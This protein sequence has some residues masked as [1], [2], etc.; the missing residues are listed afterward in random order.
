[1]LMQVMGRH[2]QGASFVHPK[3]P[4]R[5]AL[6]AAAARRAVRITALGDEYTPVGHVVDERAIANAV[7]GLLATGGSTNHTIHLV[8]I[9]RAAGIQLT[10]DDLSDLAAGARPLAAVDPSG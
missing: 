6:T 8:A 9:A 10:W 7:V 2:L 1:M 3:T 4:R 5:Y